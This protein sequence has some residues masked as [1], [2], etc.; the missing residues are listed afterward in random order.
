MA[1]A[2]EGLPTAATEVRDDFL[3]FDLVFDT[4]ATDEVLPIFLSVL[5]IHVYFWFSSRLWKPQR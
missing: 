4:V 2:K 1:I 3:G 5:S